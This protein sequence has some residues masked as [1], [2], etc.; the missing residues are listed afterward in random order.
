MA[1]VETVKV[2]VE[3]V[4]RAVGDMHKSEAEAREQLKR[5]VEEASYKIPMRLSQ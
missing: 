3:A 2:S 1:S 4:G 5:S